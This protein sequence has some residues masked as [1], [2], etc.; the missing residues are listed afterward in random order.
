MNFLLLKQANHLL[1]PLLREHVAFVFAGLAFSITS[2]M[3]AVSIFEGMF[4]N[5]EISKATS[6]CPEVA[7]S[8]LLALAIIY[9]T[10]NPFQGL[11][12]SQM[13]LSIQL[14]FTIFSQVYLTSSPKVM[15]KCINSNLSKYT[16]FVM[17]I[18]ITLLNIDLFVSFF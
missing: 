9:F 8:L 1:A 18:I 14:P 7:L 15:G 17:K 11:I 12:I 6:P 4:K 13:L 2:G 16:F 10:S 5:P 3:T